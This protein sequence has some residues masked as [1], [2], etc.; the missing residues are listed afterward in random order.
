MWLDRLSGHSSP[1]NPS[2]PHSRS[3]SPLPRRP[4]HLGPHSASQR[5]AFTPRSSSL[6]LVSNDSTASLLGAARRANGSG[7]KHSATHRDHPQPVEV[8]EKL[9]GIEIRE[10]ENAVQ[11]G[12]EFE[13]FEIKD[14]LDF[15]GLTLFEL[16]KFENTDNDDVH[17]YKSQGVDE[18]MLSIDNK[19]CSAHCIP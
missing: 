2:P 12:E 18:C 10:G 14:E 4:N 17:V 15:K 1:A 8:L 19:S 16:A 13:E 5:P 3:F 11:N 7:L 6:S 9:L